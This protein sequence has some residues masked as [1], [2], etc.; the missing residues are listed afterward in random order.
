MAPA[1]VSTLPSKS[2]SIPFYCSPSSQLYSCSLGNYQLQDRNSLS[3]QIQKP[4]I[5]YWRLRSLQDQVP[6]SMS[7]LLPHY[8]QGAHTQA[9]RKLKHSSM[10]T[11]SFPISLP[12]IGALSIPDSTEETV[13][14][15]PK[16]SLAA[17]TQTLTIPLSSIVIVNGT[18]IRCI[19]YLAWLWQKEMQG[20]LFHYYT[21][22]FQ[23]KR[24]SWFWFKK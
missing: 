3:S 13:Y 23:L 6:K 5:F 22:L 20:Q 12:G 21:V 8:P 14:P 24:L 16:R 11:L 7:K 10:N 9:L 1:R 17:V 15:Y 4:L 2:S 19:T 18:Q